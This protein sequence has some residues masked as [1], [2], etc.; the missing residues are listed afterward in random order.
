MGR[1]QQWDTLTGLSLESA[2]PGL[3]LKA[4]VGLIQRRPE[5]LSFGFG[6]CTPWSP[7]SVSQVCRHT[8][9][10]GW[11][12]CA[13][14]G[15]S[16]GC[17]WSFPAPALPPHCDLPSMPPCW[18]VCGIALKVRC[19][20][21]SRQITTPSGSLERSSFN[22]CCSGWSGVQRT[23]QRHVSQPSW[24]LETVVWGWNWQWLL[25]EGAGWAAPQSDGVGWL[26]RQRPSR[27]AT[28]PSCGSRILLSHPAAPDKPCA[29][30]CLSLPPANQW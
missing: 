13:F 9:G 20:Q 4:W 27:E 21:W 14:P 12:H 22:P 19:L 24:R 7:K 15:G 26:Y 17:R 5:W 8:H 3:T 10:R 18:C 1:P 2:K 23:S 30:S 28:A 6:G 29:L 11:P 25:V 16:A